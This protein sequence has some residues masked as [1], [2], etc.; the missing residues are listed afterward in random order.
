MGFVVEWLRALWTC[1]A[2]SP[3]TMP[4]TFN[5]R[6]EEKAFEGFSWTSNDPLLVTKARLLIGEQRVKN[7]KSAVDWHGVVDLVDGFYL[8]WKRQPDGAFAT[9][10]AGYAWFGRILGTLADR[11]WE[12]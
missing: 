1:P 5:F 2:M 9:Y 11:E 10:R 8:P 3:S 7:R 4:S 12:F 6:D